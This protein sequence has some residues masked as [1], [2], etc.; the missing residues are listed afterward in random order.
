M[1]IGA[2][3]DL[4]RRH[5][6]V[7]RFTRGEQFFPMD[8]EPYVRQCG[9]WVHRRDE[10]AVCLVPEGKLTLERL[11]EPL[12]GDFGDVFYLK[13]IEPLNVKQMATYKL[14]R[15]REKSTGDRF[16]AGLGRLAR[17][18]YTSRFLDALFSL[19]LLAR[20]RVSGDTAAAAVLACEEMSAE[21]RHRYY[22]RVVRREDWV[23]LQYWFFYP[24]NNWRSG[25]F[26]VNDHEADWEMVS[27]YL[28][29]SEAEET[30][31]EWVG[32]SSHD[33]SGDDLRRRWDDPEVEKVDGHPVVYVAAGSHAAYFAAGEY[34]AEI[35]LS[36][37]SPAARL[38]GGLRGLWRRLTRQPNNAGSP[39]VHLRVPFVDY[40]RGDGPSI[41]PGTD[42]AWDEPVLL[43][44]LPGW[45]ANYRGLWGLYVQDPVSGEDAPAGPPYNRDGTPRLAWHDPVGWTGLD[46]VP[47][48]DEALER[49]ADRRATLRAGCAA[50]EEEVSR[51]S[52]ELTGLGV[53]AEA[54]RGRPH[55][56]KRREAHGE[57]M[58]ALSKE[59]AERRGRLAS[60]RALLEA[61]G[62]HERRLREGERGPARAH[63]WRAHRPASDEKL[64]FNRLAEVWAALSI[65]LAILGVV[66]IIL[67]AREY[68]AFGLVALVSLLV[69][70]ESGFRRRLTGLVNSVSVGLAVVAALILLFEFFWTLV[71][72]AVLFAG[73]YMIWENLR[74][75]WS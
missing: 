62:S 39:E 21:V 52:R 56:K 59:L 55:L 43:D 16:R 69:F 18:G 36:F 37:L 27:V 65:G 5:E 20:G 6:P 32:Y 72:L 34:L 29:E 54:M 31:P 51:K 26:G 57:K 73:T 60:D 38:V 44:S 45:A 66:G 15:A 24:F 42:A 64:R 63:I 1:S 41:G 75:L 8:V 4:I 13:F 35:K 46:K 23:V 25:F 19:T 70:I 47:P 22:A 61:L 2:D 12:S 7:I 48:P 33:Y 58:A 28:S 50:L 10:E 40:A 9:L 3:R 71:V 74:E 49:V 67:F 17:V 68:L 11:A 53:E 14:H 30:R